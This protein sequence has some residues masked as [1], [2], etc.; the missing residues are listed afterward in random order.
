MSPDEFQDAQQVFLQALKQPADQ[1]E[2]FVREHC[3]SDR[4]CDEALTLLKFHRNETL[5]PETATSMDAP[6]QDLDQTVQWNGGPESVGPAPIDEPI[7]KSPPIIRAADIEPSAA[8]SERFAQSTNQL[9]RHR[10]VAATY[11]L[12]VMLVFVTI[13]AIVLGELHW[14]RLGVRAVTLASLGIC[15]WFLKTRH[16]CSRPMLRGLELVIITTPLIELGLIQWF[17]STEMLVQGQAIQIEEFRAI[18][19]AAASVYIAVYGMFIPSNWRRTAVVTGLIALLPTA[20]SIVHQSVHAYPSEVQWMNFLNPTLILAM[21]FTATVGSGIVHRVRREAESAKYYGQY[22]LIEEIGRGGMGVVYLGKHQMLKRPAAIKLIRGEAA[23][24]PD[25]ITQFEREVQATAT[26][27][28]WNTVQIYDYGITESNDFY[29]VME[30]L[31]GVTL[32]QRLN[33]HHTLDLKPALDIVVQLCDGLEEAHHKGLVH[34][35]I[36]PANVF[37]AEIGGFPDVV[38]LL[39]F[40]LVVTRAETE[41]DKAAVVGGT[42]AY[43]SPEQIRGDS[44]DGRSDIYAIGCMLMEC[45]TGSPPFQAFQVSELVA[46][47]LFRTPDLNSVAKIDVALPQLLEKCLAK[48]PDDRFADVAELRAACR[49]WT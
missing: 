16:D 39:D 30:Y 25:A 28:H 14:V 8:L 6:S 48:K 1:R 40:G 10:L 3:R 7:R 17:K 32:Q 9:L 46:G 35:D 33:R 2:S 41:G 13:V 15:C 43:M 12:S 45:L 47:H 38:K 34:R 49:R 23:G 4:V 27:S 20:I 11:V 37:L 36:K 24:S 29:C 21:A 18:A 44:L 31:K 19:F 26:L 22:Q 5:L 42:P